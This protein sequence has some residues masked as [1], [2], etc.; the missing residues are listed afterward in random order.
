MN[1]FMYHQV[2]HEDNTSSYLGFVKVLKKGF[3][4]IVSR[5]QQ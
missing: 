2:R 1:E 5:T 3:T 4:S